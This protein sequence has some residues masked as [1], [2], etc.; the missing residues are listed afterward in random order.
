MASFIHKNDTLFH[1]IKGQ[2]CFQMGLVGEL[3]KAN[4]KTYQ[5]IMYRIC[6]LD[7]KIPAEPILVK[8]NYEENV[9]KLFKKEN[10]I[11]EN[12]NVIGH[13]YRCRKKMASEKMESRRLF[14]SDN[15]HYR[16]H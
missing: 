11:C 8:N 10:G 3:K 13:P 6:E 16:L 4:N 1:K 5:Q 2:H 14:D 9:T 7:C 15:T 12:D